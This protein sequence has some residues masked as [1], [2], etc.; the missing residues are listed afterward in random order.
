MPAMTD[1]MIGLKSMQDCLDN[2]TPL[3]FVEC[4]MHQHIRLHF[5]QHGEEVRLTYAM[6]DGEVVKGICVYCPC[7]PIRGIPCLQV[8]YAIAEE[9][10][11]QGLGT[12]ILKDSLDEVAR[13]FKGRGP[14][15]YIEAVVGVKN[16]GSQK[17]AANVLSADP[18][19]GVDSISGEQ[20]LTYQRLLRLG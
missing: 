2:K 3:R 13:G 16:I 7:D 8:G 6:I 1:P 9:F 11:M 12:M 20:A 17:I 15:L 19:A 14:S 4:F 5:D 10:R 18:Q